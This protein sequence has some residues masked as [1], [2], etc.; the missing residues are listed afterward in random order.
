MEDAL[1]VSIVSR[2]AIA[3]TSII[4]LLLFVAIW[5]ATL[6]T[7]GFSLAGTHTFAGWTY[8]PTFWFHLVAATLGFMMFL[9]YGANRVTALVVVVLW[10]AAA[11]SDFFGA[12]LYWRLFWLC[13]ISGKDT[14]TGVAVEICGSENALLISLMVF[15]TVMLIISIAG[16]AGHLFDYGSAK[17]AGSA[18]PNR[19]LTAPLIL[20]AGMG[21]LTMVVF[22]ALWVTNLITS[23]FSWAAGS[24]NQTFAVWTHIDIFL[25]QLAGAMLS[26]M[27]ALRYGANA[28][29]AT[30]AVVLWGISLF[31]GTFGTFLYWRLGWF[32]TV[33]SSSTLQGIDL[34]I[35]TQE[36]NYLIALW[37][38]VTLLWLF[39]I[40]GAVAHGYDWQ[41]ARRSGS[42][43]LGLRKK[44]KQNGFPDDGLEG[45]G[46]E[47]L[48]HDKI[49]GG[50]RPY[51]S[52][53][54]LSRAALGHPPVF[55][56]NRNATSNANGARVLQRAVYPM[57]RRGRG[58]MSSKSRHRGGSGTGNGS[59]LNGV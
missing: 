4:S 34:V 28:V 44:K 47:S 9:R 33:A 29:T 58:A 38:L 2:T 19:T 59:P 40:V 6:I 46:Q 23:G 56:N 49:E 14:L 37:V 8:M 36:K 52:G 17:R 27:L 48:L 53:G 54:P 31:A 35:C 10:G 25:V 51:P 32:C 12:I 50:Y 42:I 41:A 1:S 5:I 45:L 13:N 30:A 20:V 21:V 16:F 22:A 3:A 11:V 26:I 39:S 55:V 7:S 18:V 57:V 15:A 24:S 43:G